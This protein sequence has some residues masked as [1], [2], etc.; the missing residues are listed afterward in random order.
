MVPQGL[1]LDSPLHGTSRRIRYTGAVSCP[2]SE[3]PRTSTDTCACVKYATL[4]VY[5]ILSD[6]HTKNKMPTLTQIEQMMPM[7]SRPE[8]GPSYQYTN[9]NHR[10]KCEGLGDERHQGQDAVS[11]P[12]RTEPAV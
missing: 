7:M 5:V 9:P 1:P 2:A 8:A 4:G 10:S 6:T 3:S 12:T 11:S